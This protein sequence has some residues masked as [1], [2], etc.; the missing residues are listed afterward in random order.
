MLHIAPQKEKLIKIK[1]KI[2]IKNKE[3]KIKIVLRRELNL[4][5]NLY[6]IYFI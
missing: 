3:K 4:R 5:K 1:I 2:K 6:V